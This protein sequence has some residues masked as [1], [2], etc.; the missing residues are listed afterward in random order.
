M[1]ARKLDRLFVRYR[2]ADD[3]RALARVFDLVA[4]DLYR[5]ALHFCRDLHEAED[6]VQATFLVAIERRDGYEPR[7]RFFSWL[8]GILVNEHR[9]RRQR[10][11]RPLD[12]DRLARPAE[13]EPI[14]RL[15]DEET[16]IRLGEALAS[17]PEPYRGVLR[18]KLDEK[19]EAAAIARRL[20]RPEGTVRAQIHR[21]LDLLRRILPAGLA[22]LVVTAMPRPALARA[23]EA[24]LGAAGFAPATGTLGLAAVE[25][26]LAVVLLA[27]TASLIGLVLGAED[28]RASFASSSRQEASAPT[29]VRRATTPTQEREVEAPAPVQP[30]P[31]DPTEPE[32]QATDW[33]WRLHRPAVLFDRERQRLGLEYRLATMREGFPPKGS[34]RKQDADFLPSLFLEHMEFDALRPLP[35]DGLRLPIGLAEGRPVIQLFVEGHDYGVLRTLDDEQLDRPDMQ[36]VEPLRFVDELVVT[37]AA[38]SPADAEVRA[39]LQTREGQRQRPFRRENGGWRLEQRLPLPVEIEIRL[40]DGR[41]QHALLRE[42]KSRLPA[43]E[44]EG[45]R[46]SRLR[47]VDALSGQ[48]LTDLSPWLVLG[49]RTPIFH[50]LEVDGRGEY[51]LP[52]LGY[53]QIQGAAV[54]LGPGPYLTP[55]ISLYRRSFGMGGSVVDLPVLRGPAQ[56][57]LLLDVDGRPLPAARLEIYDHPSRCLLEAFSDEDGRF[58]LSPTAE[59]AGHRDLD[60]ELSIAVVTSDGRHARFDGFDLPALLAGPKLKLDPGAATLEVLVLDHEGKPQ[61]RAGVRASLPKAEGVESYPRDSDR[62]GTDE[63]G[64]C[65]LHGVSGDRVELQVSAPGRLVESRVFTVPADG[66]IEYRLLP[67]APIS[68]TLTLPPELAGMLGKRT[69]VSV[70]CGPRQ[71]PIHFGN[72]DLDDAGHGEIQ[73]AMGEDYDVDCELNWGSQRPKGLLFFARQRRFEAVEPGT[74]LVVEVLA[75]RSRQFQILDHDDQDVAS[76]LILPVGDRLP[77]NL[78][79]GPLG[80]G[81]GG[82]WQPRRPV[83]MPLGR[84]EFIVLA[85]GRRVARIDPITGLEDD[86]PVVVR[87]DDGVRIS[88]RVADWTPGREVVALEL[89]SVAGV[90]LPES[91]IKALRLSSRTSFRVAADGSF[92]TEQL[93]PGRY[94][95]SYYGRDCGELRA[96]VEAS[97]VV[98]DLGPR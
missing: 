50:R 30:E 9:R 58:R 86:E 53:Q 25:A 26:A 70:S 59:L 20:G 35:D 76:A 51:E 38:G 13:S 81:F 95:I 48:L 16:N 72:L 19:L 32:S 65:R 43:F 1:L 88:G 67:T 74:D 27:T 10:D 56:P 49:S 61:A 29:E 47:F 4:T 8:A 31:V 44:G 45:S 87:L 83:I 55:R 17:I 39:L 75:G 24:A 42:A 34:A 11:R 28:E 73:V 14:D 40:A 93:L 54:D 90:D 64:I 96:E 3:G 69:R 98:L 66:R 84:A 5:F 37:A 77:A 85:R 52:A 12:A 22:S 36:V 33:V 78:P 2:T 46:P 82:G 71:D 23:R 89:L 80:Q 7:G 97:G 68:V 79:F 41:R 57:G 21:G 62:R 92:T 60:H 6:L 91:V 63:N 15:A 18:L 94:R